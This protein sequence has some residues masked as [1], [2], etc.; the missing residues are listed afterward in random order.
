VCWVDLD[1]FKKEVND[2]AR[3]HSGR[4]IWLL[5][6]VGPTART[7]VPPIQRGWPR[8]GRENEFIILMPENRHRAG[9][10]LAERVCASG[11]QQDP[12]LEEHHITGQFFGVA[13]FPVHGFFP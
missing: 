4:A 1:K 6:R 11:W 12:M 9:A 13:S 3:A 10:V 2:F 8:Y 5:A 7:E